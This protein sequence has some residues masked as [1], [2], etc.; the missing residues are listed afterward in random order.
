V[1]TLQLRY[2][3]NSTVYTQVFNA[4]SIKGFDDPDKI[5]LVPPII[6]VFAD[7]N[8]KT[9]FRA[10]RRIIT[11]DLGVIESQA[12]RQTVQE[13][14]RAGT[15]SILYQGVQSGI[16]EV[17]VS[18]RDSEF[19]NEWE[20]DCIL[21]RSFILELVETQVRIVWPEYLIIVGDLMYLKRGVKIVGTSLSPETFTTNVGKLILD[22]TGNSYPTFSETTY[23]FNVVITPTDNCQASFS[24]VGDPSV[25]A[26]NL[27]FQAFVSDFQ[28]PASDGFFYA[29]IA[30]FLQAK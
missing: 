26:G 25:V 9:E 28:V 29:D 23:V 5:E 16:V 6:Y 19:E 15:K 22:E 3:K 21:G 18:S 13:F 27:T 7:G 14:L 12:N 8:K 24:T 2:T 4:L 17:P 30:I 10:F 11:V 1:E 20:W